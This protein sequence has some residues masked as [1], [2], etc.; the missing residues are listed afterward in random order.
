MMKSKMNLLMLMGIVVASMEFHGS[1]TQTT[2]IVGYGL[3]WEMP[4]KDELDSI[5]ASHEE[6]HVNDVLF[7]NFTTGFHTVAEVTKEA[8]NNCDSRN[9]ISLATIGPANITI[10]T[11]GDHFYI[12]TIGVHCILFQKLAISVRGKNTNLSAIP[13]N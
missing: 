2:H 8:Y 4:K 3:G 10:N 11:A 12:C 9:P 5:W 13:P 1:T 7:F 6:F